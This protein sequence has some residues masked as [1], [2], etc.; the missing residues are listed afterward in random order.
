MFRQLERRKRADNNKYAALPVFATLPRELMPHWPSPFRPPKMHYGWELKAELLLEFA[1]QHNLLFRFT[2]PD[3]DEEG[4]AEDEHP[5]PR[6]RL[7]PSEL[8]SAQTLLFQ[9][10]VYTM[11][12]SLPKLA[13]SL[14]PKPPKTSRITSAINADP[15][16]IVSLYSNYDLPNVPADEFINKL[17][18]AMGYT[19]KPRWFLDGAN[20]TWMRWECAW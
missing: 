9:E 13:L 18:R 14:T 2:V 1:E 11:H 4:L 6:R 12:R 20:V 3:S 10:R 17:A 7:S 15:Y 16:S 5:E 8:R 19:E